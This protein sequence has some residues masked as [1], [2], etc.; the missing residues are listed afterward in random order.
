M[1]T[2]K[3]K[4]VLTWSNLIQLRGGH[5]ARSSERTRSGHLETNQQPGIFT[6]GGISM[7]SRSAL[8]LIAAIGGTLFLLSAGFSPARADD[9]CPTFTVYGNPGPETISLNVAYQITVAETAGSGF[10][11][12]YIELFSCTG[13]QTAP[14]GNWSYK[15]TYNGTSNPL[16][17]MWTVEDQSAGYFWWTGGGEDSY[18]PGPIPFYYAGENAP[19]GTLLSGAAGYG[20]YATPDSTGTGGGGN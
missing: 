6:E 19:G 10:N 13:S 16:S 12:T 8:H 2:K 15:G 14:S 18:T 17:C 20:P 5:P 1:L 3:K 7:R 4:N 9:S 11:P